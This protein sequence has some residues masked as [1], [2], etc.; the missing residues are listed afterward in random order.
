MPGTERGGGGGKGGRGGG[1][2]DAYG[3][4]E[5]SSAWGFAIAHVH[6]MS[7]CRFFSSRVFLAPTSASSKAG[8]ARKSR[9]VTIRA[10]ESRITHVCTHK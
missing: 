8:T 6:A 3:T 1:G 10:R 4:P 7:I 9:D 5:Q 2:G